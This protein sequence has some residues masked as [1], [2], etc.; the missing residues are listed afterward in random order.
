LVALRL[1]GVLALMAL[2]AF[3][4]GCGVTRPQSDASSTVAPTATAQSTV[5]THPTPTPPVSATATSPTGTAESA[6]CPTSN[7]SS[8]HPALI[9]TP[10]TPDRSG[11]VQA[12][13]VVQVRLP[14]TSKW[15][16]Q[17]AQTNQA[18]DMTQPSGV[19]I[20]ALNVCV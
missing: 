1:V 13:D 2:M 7:L 8:G 5:A 10:T 9:L 18:L 16:Y 15:S 19:L 17:P 4:A 6:A 3:V 14:T 11:S 12:N 20:P